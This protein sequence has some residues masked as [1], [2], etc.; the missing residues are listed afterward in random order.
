MFTGFIVA[1]FAPNKPMLHAILL[2]VI[3][4]VITVAATNSPSFEDKAPL[5]FGYTLAAITIPSL[6]LGV[7]IQQNWSSKSNFNN[8]HKL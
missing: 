7:K 3:G 1:K 5:W 6:W 2:G 8:R 4:T